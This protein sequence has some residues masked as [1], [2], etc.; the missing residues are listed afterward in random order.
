MDVQL[1]RAA[2]GPSRPQRFQTLPEERIQR[3]S[4]GF[5]SIRLRMRRTEEDVLLE[6][7]VSLL[8]VCLRWELGL[9]GELW[10]PE[11][12][13]CGD[14]DGQS[15]ADLQVMSGFN[16]CDNIH[17]LCCMFGAEGYS[18]KA[19]KWQKNDENHIFCLWFQWIFEWKC[20]K[21]FRKG[22]INRK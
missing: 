17:L 22:G 14:H 4:S 21:M 11:V 19:A 20:E 1:R 2:L 5:V 13:N 16:G 18:S 6:V 12:G 3:C 10:G 15:G 8:C 7:C 9:L